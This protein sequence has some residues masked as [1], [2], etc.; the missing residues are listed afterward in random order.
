MKT[1][2]FQKVSLVLLV[3]SLLF[4][5]WAIIGGGDFY[6]AIESRFNDG[7][8][9]GDGVLALAFPIVWGAI[10]LCILSTY[11]TIAAWLQRMFSPKA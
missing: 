3:L 9:D 2:P 5:A 8:G 11:S 7:D 4:L 10:A 1:T 6:D